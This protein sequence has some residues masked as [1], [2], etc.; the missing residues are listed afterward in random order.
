MKR[1]WIRVSKVV[2]G[3]LTFEMQKQPIGCEYD[4]PMIVGED[5]PAEV[6]SFW[7]ETEETEK[8][9]S[10]I[11]REVFPELAK[12]SPQGTV[13]AKTLYSAINVVSRCPPGPIFA[14]LCTQD[15]FNSVGGGYWTM[16]S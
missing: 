15:C 12:L 10:E 6:D 14:E 11:I 2:E 9:I 8:P 4:E 5:D 7:V 13:H 3:K 1:E 16:T